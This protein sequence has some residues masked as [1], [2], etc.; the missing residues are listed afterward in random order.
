M[1]NEPQD[2][3]A[4]AERRQIAAV[5]SGDGRA[6]AAL[7]EPHLPMLL[8]VA[9]RGCGGAL[10]EDAVQDTLAIAYQRIDSY[11]P[12]TSFRSWLATIAAQRAWTTVRGE[13]RRRQREEAA[14]PRD[15]PAT[16]EQQVRA[17]RLAKRV[18]VALAKLP[19]KRRLAATMR[20][21]GG[22]SYAEI[23]AAIG[24]TEGSTRVLVHMAL[25]SLREELSDLVDIESATE[26]RR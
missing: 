3:L 17:Q 12:G 22:L 14:T 25:K 9:A 13:M 1:A 2:D 26:A 24:S 4:A 23:A 8:R 21:D 20:L 10:A 15:K 5:R 11:R 16:P 7:V 6:F 19:E 18:R